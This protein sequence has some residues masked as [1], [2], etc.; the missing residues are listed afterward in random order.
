M[1]Y[2]ST[3]QENFSVFRKIVD[4][5]GQ[6]KSFRKNQIGA[7]GAIQSH[8]SVNPKATGIITMPTGSGKSAVILAA[9]FILAAKRVLIIVPSNLLRD[10]I[11]DQFT[12]LGPLKRVG[13]INTEELPKIK[14]IEGRIKSISNWEDLKDYDVVIAT[15]Y[16]TSPAYESIPLPPEQLF[17]LIL[18]DEAHHRP[19]ATWNTL[20]DAFPEAR[21]ILFTATPYRRD[22]L[23]IKGEIIYNYPTYKAY[24]ED[25]IFGEVEYIKVNPQDEENRDTAIAL[26]AEITFIQDRSKGLNHYLLVKASSKDH[27]AELKA[28]YDGSTSLKVEIVNSDNSL[29]V[30][31][32][33]IGRLD[34][35][36]I[37][38]IIAVD[39]LSEG[40]DIPRFKIAALHSS[41]KS[42]AVMI[43]FIG[44]FART[45]LKDVGGASFIAI[46]DD[47]VN[48][49]LKRLYEED[50]AWSEIIP[51]INDERVE[52]QIIDKN[53]IGEFGPG[54]YEFVDFAGFSLYSLRPYHHIKVY[55]LQDGFIIPDKAEVKIG[56]GYTLEYIN[57]KSK[58]LCILIFKSY[59]KPKWMS[60][61]HL[62]HKNY[63]L[64][65][66]YFNAEHK[67]LFI[68]ST[69]KSNQ[70]YDS[71]LPY[72]INKT[73]PSTPDPL[74][75][76]ITYKALLDLQDIKFFNVGLRNVKNN[77]DE[78]Y[79]N[80][81]GKNVDKVLSKKDGR[82]YDKGHA[83]AKA[84]EGGSAITLGFSSSSKLW[85]NKTDKL[86]DLIKWCDKT[87]AKFRRSDNPVT[88]TNIDHFGTRRRVSDLANLTPYLIKW[89]ARIFNEGETPNITIESKG[90]VK[91]YSPDQI[92]F[93]IDHTSI[94]KNGFLFNL[95]CDEGVYSFNYLID[96]SIMNGFRF[97]RTSSSDEYSVRL[98]DGKSFRFEDYLDDNPLEIRCIKG[99]LLEGREIADYASMQN[100]PFDNKC[101]E[102]IDWKANKVDIT[103][104][105]GTADSIHGWLERYLPSRHPNSIIYYD[106][107][108][109]E[110][111]DF[112][113]FTENGTQKTI[114][115]YHVKKCKSGKPGER[116]EE[117][118]EVCGQVEKS[119]KYKHVSLSTI[120]KNVKRRYRNTQNKKFVQLSLSDLE[121]FGKGIE[122]FDLN[123]ILVQPS[124]I[125][126][127]ITDKTEDVLAAAQSYV[128]PECNGF[129]IFS[130]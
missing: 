96:P 99:E 97:E 40:V 1:T 106:H 109:G 15:P 81:S 69:D 115:I 70:F 75:L 80:R 14:K 74:P 124:I 21:K 64:C 120:V 100:S 5:D 35:G 101:V 4:E 12:D 92:D 113:V 54:E 107:G 34:A 102:V 121:S 93:S 23:E 9:P 85:S 118:Y 6:I 47:K 44:R 86:P 57:S 65:I 127:K 30:N 98:P 50:G 73:S 122:V 119:V 11:A 104:E 42:L 7:I 110:M 79:S 18:V 51:K 84:V 95:E 56:E 24:K 72:F 22:Q 60:S 46:P 52:K 63:D 111:G 45:G 117:I 91:E 19:A 125:S 130:S 89:N 27:A 114:D 76:Q 53:F 3:N 90:V 58:N 94:S 39:M 61:D 33:I 83:F 82:N 71:I 77:G 87:A 31:R 17:D 43:Q 108:T 59:G 48:E 55:D 67:I 8:F 37:D 13:A 29:S 123:V 2:F 128:L 36:E 66:V 25:K 78:S 10:Q 28:I 62:T 103:K 20:I 68:C 88:G 38:G 49:E 126:T 116:V 105:F 32:S 16:T 26:T 129:T 112:V 41:P